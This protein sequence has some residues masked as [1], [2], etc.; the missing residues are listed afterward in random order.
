MINEGLSWFA[1]SF[2]PLRPAK[3]LRGW[4]GH[5]LYLADRCEVAAGY[6]QYCCEVEIPGGPYIDNHKAC[7]GSPLT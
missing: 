2:R 1:L 5:G 6:G 4:Q 7:D 3:L